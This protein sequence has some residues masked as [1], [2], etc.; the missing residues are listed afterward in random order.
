MIELIGI[1][2]D[3]SKLSLDSGINANDRADPDYYKYY[4]LIPVLGKVHP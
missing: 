1:G 3:F 2:S 4:S